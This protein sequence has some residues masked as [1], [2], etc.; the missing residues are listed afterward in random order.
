MTRRFQRLAAL[1]AL[2]VGALM[3]AHTDPALAGQPVTLKT[4]LFS[5]PQIT[6]GDLF[7][8]AG[9]AGG[10]LVG[11]GAPI[12]ESAVLDAGVVQRIARGH[13]LDWSNPNAIQRIMVRGG[14][15]RKIST[16]EVLTY[17]RNL[18]SGDII[19]PQD[20]SYAKI[21]SFSVPQDAPVGPE[22]VIGLMAKQP[23]R[24]GAP[25]AEHEITAAEVI[26]RDDAV[27]VTYN[28]DGISLVL[29]GKAM[30][31]ATLGQPLSIMNPVSKKVIQAIA[32]GPD[33]AVVGPDAERLRNPA[34][35]GRSQLASLH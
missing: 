30:A 14:E 25:V 24:A 4:T 28:S 6:L 17:A 22:A 2:I 32:S 18:K 27:E 16:T 8:G 9:E 3:I 34:L 31:S 11:Y 5:G 20:I 23:L 10:V 33:Q 1:L 12:G 13:G 19:Q 26:K 21:P 29:Q 35:T 7:D 15:P